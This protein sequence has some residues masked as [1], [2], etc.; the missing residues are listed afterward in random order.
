MGTVVAINKNTYKVSEN[1]KDYSELQAENQELKLLMR[2]LAHE[3]GNAL[4]LLGGSIFYLENEL[5]AGGRKGEISDLKSDY[6]YMCRL[7]SNLREY[8][9]FESTN[10]QYV[11]LKELGGSIK[12]I[13]EKL[14]NELGQKEQ[15]TDTEISVYNQD[16]DIDFV[17]E[18]SSD[19]QNAF[20]YGDSTKLRQVMINIIKN[21][22]EAMWDEDCRKGF[23]KEKKSEL[24][25]KISV[26]N[27]M[28]HILI[29]DSGKGIAKE[30]LKEIFKPMCTFEKKQ[31]IGL[32]L[33]VVKKIIEDH[34]GKIKAVSALGTGTAIH[35]Y[36]P[37]IR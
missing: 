6:N 36:L 10:K 8:N 23:D 14:K 33:A 12:G 4:T 3:M 11:S 27:N 18:C 1:Q 13:F 9:H 34:Q 5:K 25:V 16:N 29:A 17:Y 32:G 28:A 19:A 24:L 20:I 31:G 30:N 2:K 35:I 37:I 15:V 7:F 22:I 21:S 26:E